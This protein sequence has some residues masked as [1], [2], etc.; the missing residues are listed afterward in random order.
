[1]NSAVLIA[2]VTGIAG[3]IVGGVIA[4]ATQRLATKQA[5]RDAAGALL[6]QLAADVSAISNQ[7][8]IAMN[9]SAEIRATATRWKRRR[10]DALAGKGLRLW[11]SQESARWHEGMQTLIS[12]FQST[13]LRFTL[14][15][16]RMHVAVKE[17]HEALDKVLAATS[18][19][20]QA[21]RDRLS[22]TMDRLAI[23]VWIYQHSRWWW[24]PERYAP[25]SRDKKD[26]RSAT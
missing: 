22:V 2:A 18:D 19:D 12:S 25:I 14:I 9:R 15:N 7:M 4:G 13:L 3:T 5:A 16:P 8:G 26:A 6:A 20:L 24:S 23:E 1:M 11:D 17:V 10:L 21:A